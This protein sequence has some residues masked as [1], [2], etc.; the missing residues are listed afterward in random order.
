VLTQK[1]F[2]N[3]VPAA[4]EL[5]DY[6]KATLSYV[7]GVK[8]LIEKNVEMFR[9]R[10]ALK[11]AMSL[12]RIGNKYLADTEPWKTF[13]TD[14]PRTATILNIALQ[15]TANLAI[16]FEPFLPFSAARI[17]EFINVSGLSWEQLGQ[18]DLLPSSHPLSEHIDFLFAKIE[19]DDIEKQIRKLLDTKKAN[20]TEKQ[21]ETIPAKPNIPFAD[22][23]KLD[24]R[25]GTVIECGKVPKADKLLRFLIEDGIGKRTIVSGIAKWYEPESLIGKQVCFIANLEP[26][27]LKGIESQ[28]MLLSVENKDESL[29]L[30]QPASQVDNGGRVK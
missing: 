17:K 16:A 14:V 7:A 13:G 22:F 18:V 24:I 5:T 15:I 29:V 9:F 20:V 4:G 3:K 23:E 27:K 26:R 2:D 11:D 12:A 19:D 25:V 1:Y 6:D 30:I 28:G 21:S 10:D 8:G